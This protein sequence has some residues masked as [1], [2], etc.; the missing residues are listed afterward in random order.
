MN[1]DDIDSY[2]EENKRFYWSI[3]AGVTIGLILC[4]IDVIL[5]LL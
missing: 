2:F 3:K 1:S 5:R 4:I